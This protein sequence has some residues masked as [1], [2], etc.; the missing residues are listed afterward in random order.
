MKISQTEQV[1]ERIESCLSTYLASEYKDRIKLNAF[2]S[3]KDSPALIKLF[4]EKLPGYSTVK[5]NKELKSETENL[6]KI[7]GLTFK[8]FDS[9]PSFKEKFFDGETMGELSIDSNANK[10]EKNTRSLLTEIQNPTNKLIGYY[11]LYE[12]AKELYGKK[13]AEYLMGE[14]Y[15]YTLAI[16]DSTNILIPYCFAMDASSIITVGR[17]FGQLWSK[18]VKRL[19]S[20]ISVLNEVAHSFTNQIAGALAVATFFTDSAYVLNNLEHF[21]L[22]DIKNNI[23]IKAHRLTK[24]GKEKGVIE[25]TSA[26]KYIENCMESFVYSMNA[27]TRVTYESPFTNLSIFSPDKLEKIL[28]DEGRSWY[29]DSTVIPGKE[30][31][32]NKLKNSAKIK[33]YKDDTRESII[34]NLADNKIT[35]TNDEMNKKLDDIVNKYVI[36]IDK[37]EKLEY[38][39]N[40]TLELQ[41]IYMD[42]FDKGDVLKGGINYRFPVTTINASKKKISENEDGTNKFI[43]EPKDEAFVKEICNH[44]IYRYNNMVSLGTHVASCCFVG[45]AE[46]PVMINSAKKY[47]IYTLKYLYDA[48][49][50]NNNIIIKAYQNGIWVKVK[51]TRI[52]ALGNYDI[53]YEIT[54]SDNTVMPECTGNHLHMVGGE[55]YKKTTQLTTRDTICVDKSF[56]NSTYIKK[57]LRISTINK[58]QDPTDYVYCLEVIDSDIKNT[59]PIFTL[60]CGV[61]THNCRLVTDVAQLNK[62]G[63]QVNSFGGS[64]TSYGSHR[65]IP[66]NFP[67]IALDAKDFDDFIRIENDRIEDTIMLLT[68]HRELLKV[69]CSGNH[70]PFFKNG[71]M[72]LTRLFSTVGVLGIAESVDILIHKIATGEMCDPTIP[73]D[74]NISKNFNIDLKAKKE[75]DDLLRDY[76][77]TKMLTNLSEKVN[78]YAEDS[79]YKNPFNIE[80][81]PAETMAVRLCDA[82]KIIYGKK[83]VPYELY[84]NQFIPLWVK[85]SLWNRMKEDGKYN[86]LLTGGGIVHFN[87]GEKT[88]PEQNYDIYKYS[89]ECGCEHFALNPVYSLCENN[90][91]EFGN[92]EKCPICGGKIVDHYTRVIGFFTPV[93][94]WNKTRKL[95]EFPRRDFGPVESFVETT[96]NNSKI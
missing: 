66:I 29:L 58:I 46:V 49:T 76:F 36:D 81:I 87:L 77:T 50:T 35:L 22:D 72:N 24:N 86:Q 20:Y 68:A 88:T 5:F 19:S 55:V 92:H 79:E 38:M 30:D 53:K 18:P 10:S 25:L 78:R 89:V 51:P 43:I 37:K 41:K 57:Y 27:L 42:F 6:L 40:Y 34:K 96:S 39:V 26:R 90:H 28:S 84:S 82:D 70:H 48:Y 67:R 75:H 62:F 2:K 23:K 83:D 56:E 3:T 31:N 33:K 91:Y 21:S 14:V 17:Q 54:L 8:N 74:S 1:R 16:N 93:S 61:V 71:W 45:N 32:I 95:W 60:A 44:E 64:M 52:A 13:K 7:Q 9:L 47:S 12:K 65:V 15:S 69:T 4:A 94:S 11:F 85:S 63:A 59:S 80:E 73:K